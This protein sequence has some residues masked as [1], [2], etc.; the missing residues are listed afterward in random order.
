MK[1][2]CRLEFVP[3]S[4]RAGSCRRAGRS[5]GLE[6]LAEQNRKSSCPVRRFPLHKKA[7]VRARRRAASVCVSDCG[8][9][10]S[11]RL[12]PEGLI[13][14]CGHIMHADEIADSARFVRRTGDY[15]R[16]ARPVR[17]RVQASSKPG[18]RS[19]CAR[20]VGWPIR[21]ARRMT[22]ASPRATQLRSQG[23][24]AALSDAV[25]RAKCA[26]SSPLACSD[27]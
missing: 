5:A 25:P 7:G 13:A 20:G 3:L 9:S 26:G 8:G 1:S 22:A 6:S 18:G 27:E 4:G 16:R 24:E 12:P 17:S 10:R 15:I 14:H 11:P 23:S 21:A 2:L 19:G